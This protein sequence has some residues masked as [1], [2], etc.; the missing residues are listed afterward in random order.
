MASRTDFIA[1]RRFYDVGPLFDICKVRDNIWPSHPTQS[2]FKVAVE[3]LF[4]SPAEEI[5]E[6]GLQ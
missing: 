4:R 3:R 2:V 6:V 1:L 5:G